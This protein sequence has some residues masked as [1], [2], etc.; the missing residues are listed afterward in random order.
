[1]KVLF[2]TANRVGDAVLTT[3]LLASLVQQY[4]DA[5]FTIACGPY[6]A[7]LFR[8]IPRLERLIVMRKKKWNGHWVD[9]WKQC[10][11]T[12]WDLIVDL[13]N[14]AVSRLLRAK[15][16]AVHTRGSGKHKVI[17]NATVLGLSPT[18]NPFIWVTPEA[19]KEADRLMPGDKPI[20]ALGPAANWPLKQW[21]VTHFIEL[22]KSLTAPGGPLPGAAVLVVADKHERDQIAMLLRSIP[23]E[24]R[25]E[26]IGH[27]LQTAAACL[28]KA[29]L[30][31]GNDSGLMHLSAALGTP[32]LGL[33][34]PGFPLVYGPWGE[35]CAYVTTPESREQLLAN[36][37]SV[38]TPE[39]TLM[40]TLTVERVSAAAKEL[41]ART[42]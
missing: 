6:G 13:R 34:G 19:V 16:R 32:T 41:L 10:I 18:P 7:D 23:D 39:T 28:T 5:Q 33:F 20:L 35:R 21:P 38:V 22:V 30:Y 9:L 3:G 12:Q 31:V 25:I 36:A 37:P 26:L 40:S 11:G 27:D 24:R 15:R 29:R 1:M 4:P 2:I 8:G 14:S 17:D 42:P